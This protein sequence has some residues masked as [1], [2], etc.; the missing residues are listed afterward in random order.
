MTTALVQNLVGDAGVIGD[1][2]GGQRDLVPAMP[3]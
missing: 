2:F 1:T 3:P